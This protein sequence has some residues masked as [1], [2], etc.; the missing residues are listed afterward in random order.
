MILPLRRMKLTFNPFSQFAN[1]LEDAT[2]SEG[3]YPLP[4]T[5]ALATSSKAGLPSV[6]MMV[7]RGLNPFDL[8]FF[9]NYKSPKARDI[10]QNPRASMVFYWPKANRQ[11]II[12]GRVRKLSSKDSD[13]FFK[14]RERVKQIGTW[15]TTQSRQV[16]DREDFVRR[17]EALILSFREATTISRPPHWGGYKLFPT[18]FEFWQGQA[19]DLHDRF[20][21]TRRGSA[22]I[23]QRLI[24]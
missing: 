17:K 13:A 11:V 24:P 7:L 19:D 8:S 23:I 12:S 4:Y 22:W 9:A 3:E 10:R 16:R 6:R 18:K 21:Y 14:T 1:W 2:R 20:V 15:E 5:F